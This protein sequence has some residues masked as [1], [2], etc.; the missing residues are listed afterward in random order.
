MEKNSLNPLAAINYAGCAVPISASDSGRAEAIGNSTM[1]R[2]GSVGYGHWFRRLSV[3]IEKNGKVLPWKIVGISPYEAKRPEFERFNITADR[4]YQN[5]PLVGRLDDRFFDGIAVVYIASPNRFHAEQTL[6]SLH[7]G[8]VTITEKT[9]AVS[10]QQFEE[11]ID[12]VKEN[13]Y[14]KKTTVNVHY[15]GKALTRFM[16]TIVARVIKEYGRIREIEGTF[17]EYREEDFRRRWLL[18][19]IHH[20]GIFMDWAHPTAILAYVLG[21]SFD[22]CITAKTFIINPDLDP[23]NPSGAH[24]RFKIS[25]ENFAPNAEAEIKV[26]K[27]F[28]V[29]TSYKKL[30]LRHEHNA[31]LDFNYVSSDVEAE[32][33]TRGSWQ[34]SRI[35]NGKMIP[36]AS[37]YPAGPL[38]Y[39]ILID[40]M[41]DMCKNENSPLSLD[42]IIK[43]FEPQWQFQ[44][45]ISGMKPKLEVPPIPAF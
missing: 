2:L 42:D 4:Y 21:A 41:V 33:G 23:S 20:G 43:M 44:E 40:T 9:Y 3:A 30:R 39:E 10:R 19:P 18:D 12:Y 7:E 13:G 6:Q 5:D 31:V 8:K 16:P 29:G 27:G 17:Y 15:L 26:G 37:G 25:G 45:K 34:L 11:V 36:L 22:E 38:S 32:S 28:P 24:A 35:E 1:L 14:E